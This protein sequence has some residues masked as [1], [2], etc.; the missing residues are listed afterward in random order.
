MH[1]HLLEDEAAR[2]RLLQ[3]L[4]SSPR[5]SQASIPSK[6]SSKLPTEVR[7][8]KEV[9]EQEARVWKDKESVSIPTE[10]RKRNRRG[11]KGVAV[12]AER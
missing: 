12:L 1:K 10:G 4:R 2:D 11:E 8:V 7:K 5:K 3:V 9:E 6:T